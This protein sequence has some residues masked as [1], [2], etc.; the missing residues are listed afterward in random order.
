MSPWAWQH[1]SDAWRS[2]QGL[3][4]PGPA[5]AEGT[6]IHCQHPQARNRG[7]GSPQWIPQSSWHWDLAEE[8]GDIAKV[9]GWGMAPCPGVLSTSSWHGTSC[10]GPLAMQKD[11]PAKE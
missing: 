1:R 8:L 5:Q 10:T 2:V 7:W 11:L 4:G 3:S 9:V 6:D